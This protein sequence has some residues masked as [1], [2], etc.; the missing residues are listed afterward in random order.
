MTNVID[1][2]QTS[3][4]T[5]KLNDTEI[6][7]I[8]EL[9]AVKHYASGQAVVLSETGN[10]GDLSILANGNIKVKVPCGV[11]ESTVCI[12][13]P[14][15][16]VDLASL[17][18][19]STIN[20]NFYAVGDTKILSMNKNQFDGLVHTHPMIMCRVIHGMMHNLKN[21]VRRMNGQIADLRNYIYSTNGRN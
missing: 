5:D 10:H 12:L 11:G 1:T 9:F 18:S 21:I 13:H 4:V 16:M 2:L 8:A 20:A 19:G 14:G 6:R 15:D 17:A 7:S 3:D